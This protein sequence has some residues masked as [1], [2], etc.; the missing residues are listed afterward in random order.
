MR[1]FRF[2]DPV[3]V[4]ASALLAWYAN[5][6]L[7]ASEQAR[8]ERHVRECV[9]CSREVDELRRLQALLRTEE[10]E[11]SL[12][13]S[14]QRTRALLDHQDASPPPHRRFLRQWRGLPAWARAALVLQTVL[15]VLPAVLLFAGRPT[16]RLYH[17]LSEHSTITASGDVVVVVF[18]ADRP[19]REMRALLQDL[20]AHIIDGPNAAGAYTLQLPAGQQAQA[21]SVL[22]SHPGVLLA[23]SAPPGSVR[24][25]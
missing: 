21:L 16:E 17:A 5:G 6:T 18:D 13:E 25:R 20:A 23:E 7:E 24:Q 19:Q 12:A 1:L 3:H 2:D 8:V 22:R 9:A 4:D 14:R 10:A 11:P 15:L